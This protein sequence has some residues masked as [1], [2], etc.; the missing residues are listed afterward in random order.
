MNW[1]FISSLFAFE[2]YTS[3]LEIHLRHRCVKMKLYHKTESRFL[4]VM[5][6]NACVQIFMRFIDGD[7]VPPKDFLKIYCLK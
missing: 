4:F 6:E 1:N 3:T 7:N 2:F 5:P